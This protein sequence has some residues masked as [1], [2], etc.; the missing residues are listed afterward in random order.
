MDPSLQL[1]ICIDVPNLEAGISFYCSALGITVG[2]RL[3]DDWVE[4]LGGPAPIDLLSAPAG[5][6]PVPG[7]DGPR[8]YGRHWTPVHLDFVVADLD[9]SLQRAFSAGAKL[10]RPVQ[11]RRWGRLANLADPFGHG[12]CLLEFQGRGYGELV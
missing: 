10:E 2:R 5:S 9:A 3:R 11:Q 8:D 12:L 4:L 7:L 1:R 6:Q